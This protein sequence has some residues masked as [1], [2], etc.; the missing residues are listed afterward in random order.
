MD[1]PPKPPV[2]PPPCP[3][4]RQ[5]DMVVIESVIKGDA[6]SRAWWCRRCEMFVVGIRP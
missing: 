3:R 2:E 4:C 1:P 6:D 5:T